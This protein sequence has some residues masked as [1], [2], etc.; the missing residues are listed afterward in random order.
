MSEWGLTHP[1]SP[2]LD[3]SNDSTTQ[4]FCT[5]DFIRFVAYE[6]RYPSIHPFLTTSLANLAP[7][8]RRAGGWQGGV[9]GEGGATVSS[10]QV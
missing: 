8:P 4:C 10:N 3:C 5:P 1:G 9:G 7:T 2:D 6:L